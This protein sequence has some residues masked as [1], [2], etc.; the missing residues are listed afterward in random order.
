MVEIES[1]T[2]KLGD[3]EYI[4]QQASFLR[5]KPWKVRLLDEVKPLFERLGSAADIEFKTAADLQQLMPIA[6]ELFV[7][8][9]DTVYEL[10]LAYSPTL[11][12]DREYIEAHATDK[13]ILAA[14]QEVI[15]LADFL[16]VS[17]QLRRGIGLKTNGTS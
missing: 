7:G 16:G 9:L 5:S 8:G 11:Q 14:F 17:A 1:V 12:A 10:L 6:E 3:H 13:Q 4:I 15:K 2:V